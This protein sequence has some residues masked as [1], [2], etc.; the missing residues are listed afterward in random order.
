MRKNCLNDSMRCI[1]VLRLLRCDWEWF[2]VM[3]LLEDD[4]DFFTRFNVN[5]GRPSRNLRFVRVSMTVSLSEKKSPA[6]YQCWL[7]T[8]YEKYV[9]VAVAHCK[10]ITCNSHNLRHCNPPIKLDTAC[11]QE[12]WDIWKFEM[13]SMQSMWNWY[14][15]KEDVT[16]SL[17]AWI[18]IYPDS[19]GRQLTSSS[20][21]TL[22]GYR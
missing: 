11:F 20:E 6:C 22:K 3:S 12:D 4:R 5:V 16:I 8:K 15:K 7:A 17:R 19:V 10:L 18:I 2:C 21:S 14:R 1:F 9:A 13:E